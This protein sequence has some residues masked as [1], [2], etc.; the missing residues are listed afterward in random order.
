M[1]GNPSYKGKGNLTK[2][3]RVRITSA[4]KCAIR[5]RSAEKDHKKAAKLLEKDIKNLVNHVFG[6]Y[7]KEETIQVRMNIEVKTILKIK[8]LI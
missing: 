5:M 1:D 3:V 4:V 7:A 2:A 6:D 8:A